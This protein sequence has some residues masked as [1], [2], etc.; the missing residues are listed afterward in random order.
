MQ[1]HYSHQ[2]KILKEEDYWVL[3]WGK[4]ITTIIDANNTPVEY[5]KIELIFKD[6]SLAE[7]Y[8]FFKCKEEYLFS[9]Q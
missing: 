3:Y 6:K 2:Y 9:P 8:A 1:K 5:E 4:Y 7:C